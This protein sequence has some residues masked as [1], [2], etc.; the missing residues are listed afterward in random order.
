MGSKIVS[1][2]AK[3]PTVESL[4]NS[5][6]LKIKDAPQYFQTIKEENKKIVYNKISGWNKW[7]NKIIG[8]DEVNIYLERVAALQKELLATQEKRREISGQ[9]NEIRQRASEVQDKIQNVDR[10]EKFTV[11]CDLIKEEREVIFL[12]RTTSNKFQEYDQTERDLF[13]AFTNAIRDSHEKQRAQVEYTKY[14]GFILSITGSFL[15]FVYTTYRKNDLKKFI[16]DK[17]STVIIGGIDLQQMERQEQINETVLQEVAKNR[18]TLNQ[19]VH[20]L[21]NERNSNINLPVVHTVEQSGE[22]I[23]FTVLKYVGG[24]LLA[25]IVMRVLVG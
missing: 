13:T 4:K 21:S 14:L 22:T 2:L 20:Y 24:F 8:L 12:E 7:Y 11:Y 9:L 6:K 19:L 10:K 23:E 18:S 5:L 15:A 17:L 3:N 25:C 16:D 1:R